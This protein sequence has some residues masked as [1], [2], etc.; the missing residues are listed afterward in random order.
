M[1]KNIL[2]FF[3]V[4]T[5]VILLA[6]FGSAATLEFN[7]A[8]IN[9]VAN[10]NQEVTLT[11]SLINNGPNNQTDLTWTSTSNIGTFSTLP[12]L[13]EINTGDTEQL[14]AVLNIP[15]YASGTIHANIHVM[16]D[17]S[18]E[19]ADL[20]ITITINPSYTLSITEDNSLTQ[21]SNGTIII[22]N[23]GN[24]ALN[25]IKLTKVS[26]D[27]NVDF[28]D[29]NDN[30]IT[31]TNP[32]HL[33]IGASE[34]VTVSPTNI[35]IVGFE[36]KS[37]TIKAEDSTQT[38]ASDTITLS[39][40]GSFCS[41]GQTPGAED[42]LTIRNV[43]ITNDGNGKDDE[44]QLLDD[45]T[46]EV[47]VKNL[48]N[49]NI[50]DVFVEIGL[51]DSSGRNVISDLDFSNSDEEEFDIGSIR[52]GDTETATFEFKVPADFDVQNNYKLTV[53]AYSDDVGEENLCVDTAND[54][55]NDVF[56]SI[57]VV[58]DDN[59]NIAVDENSIVLS[60]DQASCGDT[61][62]VNFD[63][64]NVGGNGK[65]DQTKVTLKNAELGLN[66]E[67]IIRKDL[68]DG[69]KASG[70]FSFTIPTG[71]EA[72]LYPLEFQTFYDYRSSSDFYREESDDTW[73]GFLNVIS[74]STA[75]GQGTVPLTGN[76]I[77]S[78]N[79]ISDAV[80]GKEIKVSSTIINSDSESKTFVVSATGYQ[81]WGSLD[82]VSERILTLAPGASKDVTFTFTADKDASGSQSFTIETNAGGVIDTQQVEVFIEGTGS[83]GGFS[84]GG[85]NNLVWII[86]IVNVILV[87]LIILVAVRL[88]RR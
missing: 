72:K 2:T 81:S 36:G 83:A 18:S 25:N 84:I 45:M 62:L 53:K 56:D 1:H 78:A 13:P 26:G 6:G 27:F 43:D 75:Q 20:P 11:F 42:N 87:I 4:F 60:E 73:N 38:D 19:A 59:N 12:N 21:T 7:P 23:T 71:I 37:V 57:D 3:A 68:D 52:D 88:S 41:N 66:K 8:S 5:F 28:F 76:T 58:E 31:N 70:E 29:N 64:Y 32:I 15:L 44:W 30:L 47:D 80:A 50:R 69:D 54:L 35:G 40:P 39:I 10:H 24:Q 55:S 46:I 86:V 33:A 49:D 85:G 9:M 17:T 16:S 79:L 65:E 34:T 63:V 51:F 22:E 48:G 82:S 14:S 77:A 67:L 74:C 61:V